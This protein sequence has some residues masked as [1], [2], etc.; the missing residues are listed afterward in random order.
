MSKI[1]ISHSSANGAHALALATWLETNGWGD[2]FLDLSP[3][4]GL[5]PGE[6]WQ[7][8][9][10]AAANRCEAVVFVITPAW[11]D[12]RWCLAEFLLAKQ[13]GKK[14]F[15]VV[16]EETPLATLP[17][18]MAA[19][20][21][22]CDLVAGTERETF[23][24]SQD[25]LIPAIDVTYSRAGLDRLRNGLRKAGL[26][27]STFPWPPAEDPERPPYRGLRALESADAAVFFGR[28]ADIVRGLDVLRSMRERGTE[29]ML[30]VLG[31]S[32]SGKSSFLRAGLLPRLTRDD[33]DFVPVPVVR[34]ERAVLSG[35]AGLAASLEAA[36]RRFGTASTRGGIRGRLLQRDGLTELVSELRERTRSRL[37]PGAPAPTIVLPIDQAEELFGAEGREEADAFLTALADA[38]REPG[39]DAGAA[40]GAR[41]RL[42]ALLTI[43]SE[44]YAT[45]QTDRRLD[46]LKA[47]L[48]P[49]NPIPPTEFKA[50]IEGPASRATTAG[51]KLTI[52]PALTE[53]LLRD[54]EGR[55]ALPLLAFT[56]ERLF[57]EYGGD[58]SL[59][60]DE[61]INQLGG[62][63]GALEAAV[64]D[65]FA[66]PFRAPAIPAERS[67]RERLLRL[68]FIPWLA[69]V[70]PDTGERKRRVARANEIPEEARALVERLVAARLLVRDRRRVEDGGE[71]VVVEIAHEALLRQ[72]SALDRWLR[73]DA[74]ALQR[75]EAARR[76]AADWQKNGRTQEWLVHTG[77]RLTAAEQLRQRTEFNA[78]MGER[79]REYLAACRKRDD[80]ARD[81]KVRRLEQE[82]R[83]AQRL[84]RLVAGLGIA[85]AG[86]VIALV[87]VGATTRLWRQERDSAKAALA[88]SDLREGIRLAERGAPQRALP[89]LASSLRVAPNAAARVSIVSHLLKMRWPSVEFHRAGS[90]RSAALSA[91]GT[92][93]LTLSDETAQ[94]WNAS[95]GEPIG[96][97]LKGRPE[98][99]VTAAF[100]GVDGTRVL[101]VGDRHVRLWDSMTGA[102][103]GNAL[104]DDREIVA[105]SFSLTDA[106]IACTRDGTVL[107]WNARTGKFERELRLAGWNP[108]AREDAREPFPALP[109][110]IPIFTTDGVRLVAVLE[111]GTARVWDVITGAPAGEPLRDGKGTI[112]FAL[113]RGDRVLTVGF[114]EARLWDA[115]SGF[116][117]GTLQ[118]DHEISAAAF[119]RYGRH[120][121][122]GNAAGEA[123]IWD[124]KTAEPVRDFRKAPIV[125]T[126]PAAITAVSFS[127]DGRIL[128]G[129]ADGT[130]QVWDAIRGAPGAVPMRQNG[131]VLQV[132]YSEDGARILTVSSG[133]AAR[134]WDA[135][136]G[137][138]VSD[139][140]L[141]GTFIDGASLSDDWARLVTLSKADQD[142]TATVWDVETATPIG[143]PLEHQ[144]VDSVSLNHQGTRVLTV[145]QDATARLWDASTRES[146]G[147]PR[148][149]HAR[150]DAATFNA[151]GTH[152]MTVTATDGRTAAEVWDANT[153]ERIGG[154]L[155]CEESI[156]VPA[157]ISPD[158]TRVV[159]RTQ[160]GMLVYDVRSG[161]PIGKPLR[162][163]FLLSAGSAFSTDG[164]RVLTTVGRDAVQIW[165]ATTGDPIGQPLRHTAVVVLASFS[166]DGTRVLTT[167]QD[168]AARLWD[169]RSGAPLGSAL[170]HGGRIEV[171]SFSRDSA[172]VI[173][174]SEDGTARI[175][176]AQTG[177]PLGE[178][179]HRGAER[180]SIRVNA[181]SFSR[182]GTRVFT[183]SDRTRLSDIDVVDARRPGGADVTLLAD[184]AE[185]LSGYV[186]NENHAIVPL[187]DWPRRVEDLRRRAA[188]APRGERTVRSLVRWLLDEPWSRTITPYSRV[189]VE[190]YL[191]NALTND[192][193]KFEASR[194][195]PG[196]PLLATR[197]ESR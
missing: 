184:A 71:D 151:S 115:T 108:A 93:V 20:W 59:R 168:N 160:G 43:R 165:N 141:R 138:P 107:R 79:A 191:R 66:D 176:D 140:L 61:Y 11:R 42:F 110:Q 173:T 166:P 27:A 56:L 2:V 105:A 45:L 40:I 104:L 114:D 84:R 34:P 6:R 177:A 8:A 171:A 41:R 7:E 152:L 68:A 4:R 123:R 180:F 25:P 154:P 39:G 3:T 44:S 13:L 57:L 21:Q 113:L 86:L 1:F 50:V 196:H 87:A 145:G 131:Q 170:Q 188:D 116:R 121:V 179:I 75:L 49:L 148:P 58:G 80:D 106:V 155:P 89:Y 60:L 157:S 149:H 137:T 161:G 174:G 32:G 52:E 9:L 181:A 122:T 101:T 192:R 12:S 117:V 156:G 76:A 139:E 62:I 73:D 159:A 95:D 125:L 132:S 150:R 36:F 100:L 94:I 153:G 109:P 129:T 195:F 26:D 146:V 14:V 83:S 10:K 136:V 54:A 111:R 5:S 128:T 119:D 91:D 16:V 19:E 64:Q 18:E 63:Q 82:A 120:V 90:V 135:R 147:K 133:G 33:R 67:E 37:E 55:D 31:A 118:H 130:T 112:R 172:L 22:L 178:P 103:V 88:V 99:F 197:P 194:A 72:W 124:A 175:W 96:G 193:M 81:E 51:R 185:V 78:L 187:P 70:D 169:G 53:Q 102:P 186:L 142:G 190:E 28:D 46:A 24:V 35:S 143:Q 47:A 163:D 48:F 162:G 23:R 182:D 164:T 38:L 189:T 98:E 183:V 126:Q 158:G 69:G 65:A 144:S 127:S 85:L 77:E 134:L 97:P 17:P 92:R 29:R 167:S 15:G 74:E 30:V